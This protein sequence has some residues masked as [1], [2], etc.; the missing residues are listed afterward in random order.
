MKHRFKLKREM[1]LFTA[2]LYGIGIILG[3]GIY[4]LIGEGA[5][6]AG[7][8]LW[9]SFILAAVI[10]SL[11]GM[12][13]AELSSMYPKEA[14]EYNY[15][16]K[17][18]NKRLLPFVVGWVL[19]VA[20]IVSAAT[21]ALGFAGYFSHI[22]GGKQI[23]I[24]A[25]LIA[26]LSLINYRGI[27]ESV[28]FNVISSIIEVAG[29]V[30][31]AAIGLM[32]VGSSSVDFFDFSF[33]MNGII[34]ATA[35]IFFAYI[36]FEGVANI[37]EE[38]KNAKSVVPKALLLSLAISTVLYI[39]VAVASVGMLGWERLFSAQGPPPEGMAGAL[40]DAATIKS[41]S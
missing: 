25:A 7:N 2:T 17:A 1:T 18:F 8:A 26:L 30:I 39:L 21:V 24:A 12:S 15:A 29:L 32:F 3:A 20:G 37:A 33:G 22:F 6:I 4:A 16:R 13:Y 36:G 19:I 41:F 28:R 34:A 11:T 27:K 35:L 5:G 31:I 9:V 23:L 38:T 10:A 40:S 14:A